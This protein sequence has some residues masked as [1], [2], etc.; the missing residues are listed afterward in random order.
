[1]L[2]KI[3][4]PDAAGRE[5]MYYAHRQDE[6]YRAG[7][8]GYLGSIAMLPRFA[9]IGG[10]ARALGVDRVLDVGCGTGDL[11]AYLDPTIGYVGVDISPTAI[12]QARHRFGARPDTAFVAADFRAWDGPP[13][14][15][16]CVVWAGIGGTWTRRGLRGD[17]RDWLE[18]LDAAQRPLAPGGAIVLE[19]VTSHWPTLEG[20]IE[21]RYSYEA[22]CDLDCFQ[23]EESPR[24]SIRVLRTPVQ[25][26]ARPGVVPLPEARIKDLIGRAARMGQATDEATMNLG[27]GYVYYGLTR[28]ARPLNVVCIGSYR[29]FSPLCVALAL[30][31]EGSGT[32]Y[33]IDPGHIDRYWHDPARVDAL[34]RDFGVDGH[35]RHLRMTSEAAADDPSL[36]ETI[37]LLL[38]DGD[39]SYES[40]RF[41][42]ERLG[43]R[44]SEG[45]YILLHDSTVE[46]RGF[47]PWEV[48]R[49][50]QE[51]VVAGP[52][53]EVLT[54]PFGAGLTVVRR[55]G[56]GDR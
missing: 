14:P 49:Y 3:P 53:L 4:G 10:Y 18:V 48:K 40:V 39:H 22:G 30:A 46:G 36:P 33:F 34:A 9:T 45:G 5:A 43:S 29:G 20:L 8:Y 25:D 17:P 16:D 7:A 11:V 26:V 6:A 50:L 42:F 32:C 54:L 15:V 21:G 44:V 38:I 41:D 47:T 55:R 35:W 12:A 23:S 51:E 2:E 52:D 28:L 24:R 27:L 31:D 1:V 56:R 37:D 19:L 13:A